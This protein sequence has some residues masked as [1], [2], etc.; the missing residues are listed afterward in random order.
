VAFGQHAGVEIDSQ[1]DAFFVAFPGASD[2]P[3]AAEQAQRALADG[4]CACVWA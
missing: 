3:A 4:P 2:A 1:G